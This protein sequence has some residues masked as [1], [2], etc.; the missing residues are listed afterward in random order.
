MATSGMPIPALSA[1]RRTVCTSHISTSL[2][3]EV[4]T[5]APVRRLAVHLEIASEISEPPKPNT[6]AKITRLRMSSPTPCWS[7]IW[8]TPSR[9]S[10]MLRMKTIARLVMI[11]SMTRLNID[12]LQGCCVHRSCLAIL[13]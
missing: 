4:M 6:A 11:K 9:L 7:R 13:M 1:C 12:I 2:A 3:G 5:R 10:T 8:P